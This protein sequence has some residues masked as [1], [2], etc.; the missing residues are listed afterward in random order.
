MRDQ[1]QHEIVR[2]WG[3]IIKVH[4][5]HYW[6]NKDTQLLEKQNKNSTILF[7]K[8]LYLTFFLSFHCVI[9]LTF[10]SQ[11]AITLTEVRGSTDLLSSLFSEEVRWSRGIFCR[12]L[13]VI[14][15]LHT[16]EHPGQF[17]REMQLT[18]YKTTSL[19]MWTQLYSAECFRFMDVSF[20]CPPLQFNM[21]PWGGICVL[22]FVGETHIRLKIICIGNIWIIIH[23]ISQTW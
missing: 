5:C 11:Q 4:N 20:I 21:C 8:V 18:L 15:V 1:W 16:L 9:H 10:T 3:H 23:K 19:V 12:T 13:K 22:L 14:E 2:N 17:T 7:F 6:R